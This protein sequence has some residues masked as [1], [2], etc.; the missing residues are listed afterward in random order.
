MLV[1]SFLPTLCQ[2]VSSAQR[3]EHSRRKDVIGSG[4]G[5]GLFLICF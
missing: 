2:W 5:E 4:V 3:K 1:F